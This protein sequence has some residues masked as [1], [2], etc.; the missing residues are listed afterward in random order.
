MMD[1]SSILELFNLESQDIQSI[2]CTRQKDALILEVTLT[3]TRPPCP[4][5]GCSNVKIKGYVL[6]KINHSAL[7]DR[8][9]I[10]R[11]HA[12]RYSCPVCHRTYYEHNPFVFKQMKISALTVINILDDLKS[13]PR[14][15]LPLPADTIFPRSR[16][17]GPADK[18]LDYYNKS[19][20]C[21]YS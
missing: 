15:L 13:L 18:F 19:K 7:N 14:P 4:D 10:I 5:C 2:Q 11:Y 1:D 21:R 9:C 20:L 3:D 17:L 12:R 6:K 8:R 16:S